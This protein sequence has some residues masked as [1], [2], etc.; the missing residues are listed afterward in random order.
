MGRL[1][2]KFFSFFFLAQITS[3]LGVIVAL[4]IYNQKLDN[5]YAKIEANPPARAVVEAAA[6]TLE[7]GGVKSLSA[8][9]QRW[10][11][12]RFPPLYAVNELNHELL[13]RPT[14]LDVIAV[15]R[16]I[17]SRPQLQQAVQSVKANDGHTYLLFVPAPSDQFLLNKQL[18]LNSNKRIMDGIPATPKLRH[19]FPFMPI[20]AGVVASFIFAALLARYF[21]TPIKQLKRA[22]HS[23]AE[24]NLETRIGQDMG[25]RHDELADLG[26]AF[27]VMA[28]RLGILMHSQTRLLHQV[29]HEMRSPLAR[30]QLAVGLAKQSQELQNSDKLDLSLLR[31]E[32]ESMR[33]DGLVG[34][35]LELSRL[36]SGNVQIQKESIDVG[37]LLSS[38][39]EDAQYEADAK[40]IEVKLDAQSGQIVQGQPDLLYRALENIIRNAIKYSPENSQVVIATAVIKMDSKSLVEFVQISVSDQGL[41]VP[42][43]E[44]SKIFEPFF[45]GSNTANKDGHGVG[46]A[47]AKQLLEAHGGQVMASNLASGGL[48]VKVIFP[49]NV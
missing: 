20:L 32:R 9:I 44:L 46:L 8:L 47:I 42:E 6:T 12:Q 22:F 1:Y 3:V 11:V 27:D 36:E 21:S 17:L 35:L 18:R 34:E 31:I 26:N 40:Q 23:V 13:N 14:P 15:A 29:S 30:L 48:G 24:G 33:M 16:E 38:V 37:E 49:F 45:R 28:A 25:K 5:E 7:F 43:G 19:L 39:L 10:D 41:G 2:W 4:W